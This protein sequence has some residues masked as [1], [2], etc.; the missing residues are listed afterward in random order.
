MSLGWRR[1]ARGGEGRGGEGRGGEGR[2]EWVESRKKVRNGGMREV[3]RIGG[4][5]KRR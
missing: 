2:V 3:G 1:T 5:M 4:K